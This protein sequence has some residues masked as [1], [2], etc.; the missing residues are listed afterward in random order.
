M[1]ERWRRKLEALDDVEPEMS[2]LRDRALLGP[3]LPGP[4]PHPARPVIAGVVAIALAVGSFGLL[5][6]TFGGERDESDVRSSPPPT[7]VG[8]TP[9]PEV[10]CDVP[11]YDPD[12]ALLGDDF[13][14]VFGAIGPREIPV[15]RLEVAGEPASSID[16]SAADALRTYLS[17]PGSRNAPTDGWRTITEGPDEVIYAAPPDGGYS[18]WW[19][20]RF[21]ISPDGWVARETELVDQHPTPAQLGHGLQLSW[22][23]AVVMADGGWNTT[24][25][26]ANGRAD[27]WTIGEDGYELWGHVHVFDRE[28]G[29]EIGRAA[30]TIG[31]WGPPLALEPGA[32]ARIPLSLGG[33][34]EALASDHIYDIIA[35][36]PELG[37]ASPMGALRVQD[38]ASVETVRVLTYPDSGIHMQAL[39]GGRLMVHNGCLAVAE[40]SPRPIYV[41]WPD[42]YALVDRGAGEPVLIDAVGREVARLGDEV[43]LGGGYVPPDGAEAAAIGGIP[44]SCRRSGESYFVTSGLA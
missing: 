22:T 37:L 8:T 39:G 4:A 11:R 3:R 9:E 32:S 1:P 14:S 43:T 40:R 38:N 16:G 18:D 26:L 28:R 21:T 17:D 2:K 33:A 15:R 35:C 23:G 19:V 41:L 7:Q 6:A 30:E 34:I 24:L 25:R 12:V 36:V 29:T 5:R 31:N 20:T 44:E 27:R 13:S 10:V 42:G